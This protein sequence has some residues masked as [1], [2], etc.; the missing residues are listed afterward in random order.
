MSDILYVGH[1]QVPI[2]VVRKSEPRAGMAGRF[3]SVYCILYISVL[4]VWKK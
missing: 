4:S 1:T 3:F 2:C